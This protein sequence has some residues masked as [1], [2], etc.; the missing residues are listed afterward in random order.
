MVGISMERRWSSY[1][2]RVHNYL[3]SIDVML[4]VPLKDRKEGNC[5]IKNCMNKKT[6]FFIKKGG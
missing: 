6:N 4:C 5:E 1:D 3:Y 2:L